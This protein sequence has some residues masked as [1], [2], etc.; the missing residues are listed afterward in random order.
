[1]EYPIRVLFLDNIMDR[2]G[3]QAM[4]MNYY[5]RIDRSKIQ[6]DFLIHRDY[7]GAYDEE[8]RAL[9][10]K[11]YHIIPPYP[12]NYFKYK[13]EIRLFFLN[14][15][16]YKILH[17]SMT[18]TALFAFQVAKEMGVPVR[19]CHAHTAVKKKGFSIKQCVLRYYRWRIKKYITHRFA[20][21]EA[22]AEYV[23]GSKDD[24]IYM[25]N[26]IDTEQFIHQDEIEADVRN[27]FNIGDSFVIGHVGRFFEPKNHMFI[28]DIFYE[29][30]K[31]CNDA[32]L[33]LVGGGEIDD[34]CMNKVK[35]KVHALNLDE[36]VYFTG[37][38]N[39]V[40]RIMQAFNVFILPS[41]WEGLPVVMV[42]AQ[43][44]GLKCFISDRVSRECILTDN[45]EIIGLEEG[46]SAW[47]DKILSS[48]DTIKRNM[49]KQITEKGYDINQNA[50]WLEKF[51][52]E[53]EE[54]L[55]D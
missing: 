28:I 34:S 48:K 26:A 19:I 22:A 21:G 33:L 51:Y 6:F 47:A 7:E 24:V 5:R 53:C 4:V 41:L 50:K 31:R 18:E 9:G 40:N 49:K 11:I 43:T 23:F 54:K 36:S 30:K 55:D 20:C 38:R 52:L 13:R 2:G 46:A 44:A 27:E 37:V 42:E 39:D 25:A 8:I 45:V 35:A 17:S 3:A 32:V 10:G 15:P 16:E 29:V 14:H 12:Q 1:M